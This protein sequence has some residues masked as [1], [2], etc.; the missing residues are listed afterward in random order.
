MTVP[1]ASV[2]ENHGAKSREHHI[3]FAGYARSVEPVAEAAAVK[4]APQEHF[5]FGILAPDPAHDEP[6]LVRRQYVGDFV[7]G[8]RD[9]RGIRL[10]RRSPSPADQVQRR[11]PSLPPLLPLRLSSDN[12]A[13]SDA[14]LP[15]VGA[16]S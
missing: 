5:G 2:D 15:L 10:Q 4:P 7:P 8:R 1:E 14:R 6:A 9:I 11:I 12:A 16:S 13:Q 3:R